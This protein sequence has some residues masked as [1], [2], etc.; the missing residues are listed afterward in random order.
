MT[1]GGSWVLRCM[2]R[3]LRKRQ[4]TACA[5]QSRAS[6]KKAKAGTPP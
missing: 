5:K 4:A 3:P 6:M 1:D 2:D